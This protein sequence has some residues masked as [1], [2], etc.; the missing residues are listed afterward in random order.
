M[1]IDAK[2]QTGNKTIIAVDW[3]SFLISVHISR[4]VF[5]DIDLLL[6]VSVGVGFGSMKVAH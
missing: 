4:T 3:F 1:A 6:M 5:R 2:N